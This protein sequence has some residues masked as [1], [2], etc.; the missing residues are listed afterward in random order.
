[1]KISRDGV[2]P[3]VELGPRLGG[4]KVLYQRAG[5]LVFQPVTMVSAMGAA[6]STTPALQAVFGSFL[7]FVLAVAMFG[8]AVM[9]GYY[10]I[11]LPAEQRF[12]QVQSQ[13]SER[14][15]LKRDTEAILA[16]LEAR[17]DSG[18]GDDSEVSR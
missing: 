6:W 4:L 3:Q 9:G 11:V 16:A 12:N 1:M 17:S 8:L 13:R 10:I 7:V 18:D 14:S 5:S 2:L 15:P